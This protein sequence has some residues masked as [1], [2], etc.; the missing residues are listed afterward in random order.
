MS[1]VQMKSAKSPRSCDVS[2]FPQ[3]TQGTCLLSYSFSAECS[4]SEKTTFLTQAKDA[5]EIGLLTKTE[6]DVVTSKQELHTFVKAAYALAITHKWLGCPYSLVAEAIQVCRE[7]SAIYYTYCFEESADRDKLCQEIMGFVHKVKSLLKVEPFVNSDPGSFIPD[8]YRAAEDRTVVFTMEDFAMGMTRFQQHH[9]SVCEASKAKCHRHESVEW[10]SSSSPGL[11]VTSFGTATETPNTECATESQAHSRP[12]GVQKGD[13]NDMTPTHQSAHLPG[14][15]G[16][17]E[18]AT[19]DELRDEWQHLKSKALDDPSEEGQK[20]VDGNKKARFSSGSLSSSL[21]SSWGNMKSISRSSSQMPHG[22]RDRVDSCCL[23]ECDGDDLPVL[24]D[25]LALGSC[26]ASIAKAGGETED[27][28]REEE[29]NISSKSQLTS[30]SR[31]G[32]ESNTSH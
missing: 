1:S 26:A 18:A 8:T 12:P 13:N 24:L 32:K 3:V 29:S 9:R 19:R 14:N 31:T 6:E 15:Q 7:A 4:S 20:P 16:G 28:G 30:H 23:T 10:E 27:K 17:A 22:P 21:G 25:S 5:F 2:R 11:C